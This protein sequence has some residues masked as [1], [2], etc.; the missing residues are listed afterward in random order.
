M[1]KF[2]TTCMSTCNHVRLESLWCYIQNTKTNSEDREDLR[3]IKA[4]KNNKLDQIF[5]RKDEW[6]FSR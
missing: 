3:K 6:D 5:T 4:A 1:L 2:H